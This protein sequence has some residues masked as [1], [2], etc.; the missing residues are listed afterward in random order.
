MGGLTGLPGSNQVYPTVAATFNS[1]QPNVTELGL[2][3][4]GTSIA[5]QNSS[6]G[7][8]LVR[9][10]T[11]VSEKAIQSGGAYIPVSPSSSP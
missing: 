9:Q 4:A 3:T 2:L 10:F 5:P 1:F 6:G 7:L 8:V 11:T